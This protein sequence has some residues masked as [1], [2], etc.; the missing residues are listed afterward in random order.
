MSRPFDISLGFQKQIIVTREPT[1][2]FPGKPFLVQPAIA[3]TDLG[4]NV[5]TTDSETLVTASILN[6]QQSS[7]R[8]GTAKIVVVSKGHA[9]YSLL[10]IDMASSCFQLTFTSVGRLPAFSQPFAVKP[11]PPSRL[12]FTTS[13]S[14]AAP[15]FALTRQPVIQ[16]VDIFGNFFS[17]LTGTVT[18]ELYYAGVAAECE[19]DRR[20]MHPVSQTKIPFSQSGKDVGLATFTNLRI[21]TASE[22]GGNYSLYF[23]SPGLAPLV[24]PED[25]YVVPG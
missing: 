10:Q 20:C 24:S 13:P 1:G 12:A 15:G 6:Q 8:G 2:L 18:A 3:I 11:L 21:D 4:G 23:T 5:L 9:E 25:I 16:A 14:G 19:S 17:N 22:S 7:L